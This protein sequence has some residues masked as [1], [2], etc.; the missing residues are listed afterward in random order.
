MFSFLKTFFTTDLGPTAETTKEN[1]V[2]TI[3]E[4]DGRFF[5]TDRKGNI[6]GNPSG[7]SRRRDATRGASRFG[8]TLAA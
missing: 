2:F 1:T 3:S 4:F 6:A 8:L 5:L 7:Y